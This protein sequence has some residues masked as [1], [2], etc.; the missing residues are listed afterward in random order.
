MLTYRQWKGHMCDGSTQNLWVVR[1]GD[2]DRP[3]G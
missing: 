3:G 1:I 2:G